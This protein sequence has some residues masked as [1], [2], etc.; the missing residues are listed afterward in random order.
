MSRHPNQR[1]TYATPTRSATTHAQDLSR[2]T[3]KPAANHLSP[4]EIKK[5]D[6]AKVDDDAAALAK[7]LAV[8]PL[9]PPHRHVYVNGV[10]KVCGQPEVEST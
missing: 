6:A 9:K 1:S 3:P 5:R 10:C 7:A 4:A 2:H 8:R